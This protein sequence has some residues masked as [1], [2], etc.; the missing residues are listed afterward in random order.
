MMLLLP[1]M[2]SAESVEIDGIYYNLI[3]KAKQAEVTSKPNKY[4]G[5]VN[6][7]A[8]VTYGSTQYNVTSIGGS[9]FR[10]C[11]GL[12]SITIPNSVTSIGGAAFAGCSGLTSVTIPN[13]VTNIGNG[14][15]RDCSGLTSVTIPNSVTS[16]GE[17]AFTYCSGLTSITIPNSV[18]SIGWNAFVYC[19]GLTSVT[20]PGSVTSIGGQAFLG[21][22]SLTTVTIP[23][24]VTSIGGGAFSGCSGLTSLTIGSGVTSIGASAFASCKDLTDVYCLAENVPTASSDAFNGSYIAYAT[25][26]VPDASVNT[27]KASAPWSGFG[28]IVGIEGGDIAET[29]KCAMPTISYH[30][31]MLTFNCETEGVSYVSDIKDADIK[32]HYSSEIDLTATYEISVYATATGYENSDVTTATLCW[33]D[34]TPRT[35]GTTN[36]VAAVRGNAIL[37]QGS[38]R[39]LHISGVE[40]GEYISVYSITGAIVGGAKSDGNAVSIPCNLGTGDVAIIKIGR[41]AIKT[42]VR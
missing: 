12:T 23:N 36:D 7:P 19:S 10:G 6:I 35:E 37:I 5:G 31:G 29:P 28:T 15:F 40:A 18:T 17:S 38:D 11:S 34:A 16:I 4:T 30:D 41:N 33:L 3:T 22:S 9:A 39:A 27:Y 42:I 14:A 20:I 26:H 13:S 24:S 32:Q 1:M 2:A 25:L 21:C 8:S